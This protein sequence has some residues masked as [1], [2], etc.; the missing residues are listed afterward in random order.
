VHVD[1]RIEALRAQFEAGKPDVIG[2]WGE[3]GTPGDG[4]SPA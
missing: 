4:R 1:E 2:S 3:D